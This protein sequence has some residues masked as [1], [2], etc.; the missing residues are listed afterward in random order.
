MRPVHQGVDPCPGVMAPT[1]GNLDDMKRRFICQE[2]YLGV[3]SP[4]FDA[5]KGKNCLCRLTPEG[6]EAALGIL[7]IQPEQDSEEKIEDSAQKLPG[8]GLPAYL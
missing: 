5:L 8:D 3:E 6:F 4:A 1:H 7:E 2:E